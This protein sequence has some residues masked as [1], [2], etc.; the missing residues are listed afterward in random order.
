MKDKCITHNVLG[1]QTD[2]SVV[3]GFYCIALIGHKIAGKTLLVLN[4]L[5]SPNGYKKN[6]K[7]TYKYFKD[8]Y[9]NRK[10]KS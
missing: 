3:C 10:R 4:N 6:D 9:D 2:D 8:K 1:I 7:V 5:F